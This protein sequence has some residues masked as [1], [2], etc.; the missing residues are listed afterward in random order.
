[1][2]LPQDKHYLIESLQ[3]AIDILKSLP[4]KKECANCEFHSMG[5]CTANNNRQ[6]PEDIKPV[7]CNA[8]RWWGVPF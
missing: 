8:W 4:D 7:G 1:M 3:R 6:I 2:I 5:L